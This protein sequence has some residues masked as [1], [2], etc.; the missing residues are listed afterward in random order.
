MCDK[1]RDYGLGEELRKLQEQERR[2]K[3]EEVRQAQEREASKE[4]RLVKS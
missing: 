3:Q 4:R 1:L 2:E